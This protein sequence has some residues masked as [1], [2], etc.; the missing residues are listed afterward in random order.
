MAEEE[1]DYMTMLVEDPTVKPKET[2]I[3]RRARKQKESEQK[4]R[5][6]SKKELEAEAEAAR[7]AALNTALDPS[8]KGFQMM[9]KLGFKP[10]TALGKASDA[11]TEP[12][13]VALKEDR[14][15]IGH[16]NAR[17][18]KFRTEAGEENL[19]KLAKMDP[20]AYRERIRLEREQKRFE[21]QLHAAQK[22]AE[23]FAESEE[24]AERATGATNAESKP[25][26]SINVL[27]RGLVRDRLE[28]ERE[29][30]LRL[31]MQART[32]D[33]PEHDSDEEDLGPGKG[34]SEEAITFQE[35]D[36]EDP[37]LNDF[38]AMTVDEQL[39]KVVEHL[40]KER[41]YCFYCKYQYPDPEMDGCP[42]LTEED[43]D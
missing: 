38:E 7:D 19:A 33:D 28:K 6:K 34:P 13:Q 11:R 15:G 36:E 14:G 2:S 43:H 12:I 9:A 25:L 32:L 37:E 3:Q 23:Q 26:T 31:E 17:K 40:R 1:D 18:R 10:G 22:V 16:L 30:Q 8:N 5:T 39:E 4:G 27:W 24:E 35:L 29:K 42:G 20:E 41:Q 21:G